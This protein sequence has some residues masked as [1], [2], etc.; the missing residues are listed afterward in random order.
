MH[1]PAAAATTESGSFPLLIIFLFDRRPIQYDAM[2]DAFPLLSKS[3]GSSMKS[4]FVV[5]LCLHS[6]IQLCKPYVAQVLQKENDSREKKRF[7]LSNF[8]SEG[9]I[10]RNEQKLTNFKFTAYSPP[11]PHPL[12]YF[13]L[14]GSVVGQ[15]AESWRHYTT[16]QQEIC[17]NKLSY[18]Q[19]KSA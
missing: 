19:N 7:S 3:L 6:H 12:I 1:S 18:Q 5:C 14:A 10:Y 9:I 8:Y 16:N 2:S 4:R 13:S 11:H 17:T 15:T